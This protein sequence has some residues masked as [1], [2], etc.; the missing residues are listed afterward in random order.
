M[1][2]NVVRRGSTD[3]LWSIEGWHRWLFV[4]DDGASVVV[5]YDGLNLVPADST[6]KLEVL[7]FYKRGQLVRT[8]RLGDLY[9]DKAQLRRTVS[10]LAWVNE[11]SINQANQLVVEL[12]DG[13][14]TRISMDTGEIQAVGRD[15]G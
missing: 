6:L 13:R 12:I 9:R 11:I 10:H 8:M 14:K 5:A 2:T 7:R 15:G 3:A 4:S 1:R